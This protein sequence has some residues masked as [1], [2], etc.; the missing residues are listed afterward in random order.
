MAALHGSRCLLRECWHLLDACG[1]CNSA[2]GPGAGSKPLFCSCIAAFVKFKTLRAKSRAKLPDV[3]KLQ[4]MIAYKRIGASKGV[5][6]ADVFSGNRPP[7]LSAPFQ[8]PLP[9][10]SS[11]PTS[12]CLDTPFPALQVA[13]RACGRLQL[14]HRLGGSLH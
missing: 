2:V 8:N 9:F 11:L 7:A 3:V 1:R 10:R 14:A 5:S 12:S 13:M 4:S 6:L